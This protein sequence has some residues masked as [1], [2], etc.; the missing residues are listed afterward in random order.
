VAIA[1]VVSVLGAWESYSRL[2]GFQP[3]AEPDDQNWA[4]LRS[5][6]GRNSTVFLGTSRSQAALDPAVWHARVGG[7][8]AFQLAINGTSAIPILEHFAEDETFAGLLIVEVNPA[9][10][11]ECDRANEAR[12]ARYIEAYRQTVSNPAR[13]AEAFLRTR[14]PAL[15]FMRPELSFGGWRRRLGRTLSEK[16]FDGLFPKPP[17]W[18]RRADRF[19]PL[20]F[21]RMDYQ[22]RE[23]HLIDWLRSR[24]QPAAGAELAGLVSRVRSSVKRIERRGGIVIL[25]HLP[26][27][28][29][30]RRQEEARY[31][32]SIYWAAL[33]SALEFTVHFAVYP[34]LRAFSCPDGSHLDWRDSAAFTEALAEVIGGMMSRADW[35]TPSSYRSF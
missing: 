15:V 9:L 25:V 4:V 17:F 29:E 23:G 8:R 14:L 24:G 33:D 27:C 7:G 34:R 13:W 30:L 3:L 28:G 5:L 16:D 22:R 26:H 32:P 18:N 1:L 12:A 10:D 19:T 21:T 2:V 11:F 31:P 20:D 6:V 35:E